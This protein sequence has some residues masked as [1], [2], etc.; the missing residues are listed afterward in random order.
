MHV[1]FSVS[2]VPILLLI[3]IHSTVAEYDA[4]DVT[5]VTTVSGTSPRNYDHASSTSSNEVVLPAGDEKSTTVMSTD[6]SPSN[7]DATSTA[8][9]AAEAVMSPASSRTGSDIRSTL[10]PVASSSATASSRSGVGTVSRVTVGT[11]RSNSTY[12]DESRSP[13]VTSSATAVVTAPVVTSAAAAV[14]VTSPSSAASTAP[15]TRGKDSSFSS[16]SPVSN[17]PLLLNTSSIGSTNHTTFTTTEARR[18]EVTSAL[19]L[20]ASTVS[21]DIGSGVATATLSI[22]SSSSTELPAGSSS[23]FSTATVS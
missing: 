9:A 21:L 11:S 17:S 13:N 20:N 7:V 14:A 4:T 19:D 18:L 5:Q 15:F 6:V 8:R 22:S 1:L 12:G 10:A 16:I 2:T 23:A 3:L